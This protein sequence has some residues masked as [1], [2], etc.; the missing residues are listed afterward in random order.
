M[1]QAKEEEIKHSV[2]SKPLTAI[3]AESPQPR[4]SQI[5]LNDNAD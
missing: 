2:K 4:K 5:R 3:N 1:K